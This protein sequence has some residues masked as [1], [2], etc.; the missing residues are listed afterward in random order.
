MRA[1]GLVLLAISLVL[2][3]IALY[4]VRGTRPPQT[5]AVAAAGPSIVVAK[6]ALHFGDRIVPTDLELVNWPSKAVPPGAFKT[7]EQICEKGHE[8][9]ALAAIEPGEPVLA[10]KVSEPNGRASLSSVIGK[11]MLAVTLR[12]ND[13]TGVA[14][15]VLPSDRVDVLLTRTEDKNNPQTVI[16]LQ[17][18]KVLGVDQV[19]NDPKLNKPIVAKAVTLE[20]SPSDAQKLTLGEQVGSLSL[21]LRNVADAQQVPSHPFSLNDL[22]PAPVGDKPPV[23]DGITV[24]VLRGAGGPAK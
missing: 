17:N 12:V 18:V 13:A 16:L 10:G 19:A 9:V 6:T 2:G 22:R 20:V 5:A 14:G 15:F 1:R 23:A 3:L 24:T 7:I 21:A 4:A 11:D 8:R